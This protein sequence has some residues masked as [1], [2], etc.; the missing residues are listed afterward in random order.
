MKERQALRY[1]LQAKQFALT[2]PEHI[3]AIVTA[4]P[5]T[6]YYPLAWPTSG[7]MVGPNESHFCP[8]QRMARLVVAARFRLLFQLAEGHR[9]I[10]NIFTETCYSC[11]NNE[12]IVWY[13]ASGS[14]K[15]VLGNFSVSR[16]LNM[17]GTRLIY[18]LLI[19][20]I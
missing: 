7:H 16:R 2:S 5:C 1:F 20:H 13:V 18:G 3:G 11:E 14:L 4:L 17:V 9:T 12:V 8:T 10:R 6:P 19:V 15:L